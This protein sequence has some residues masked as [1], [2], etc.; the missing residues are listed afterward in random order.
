MP[1]VTRGTNKI[2]HNAKPTAIPVAIQCL[3]LYCVTLCQNNA[4]CPK[5]FP[6]ATT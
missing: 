4:N 5:I 3:E 1:N 6:A 2:I